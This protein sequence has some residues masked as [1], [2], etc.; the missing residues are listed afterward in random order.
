[1]EPEKPEN[2][3]QWYPHAACMWELLGQ[4]TVKQKFSSGD[5]REM[6]N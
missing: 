3:L 6:V 5:S 1:M 4:T 2:V